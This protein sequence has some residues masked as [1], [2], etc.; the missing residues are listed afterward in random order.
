MKI[1]KKTRYAIDAV[2]YIHNL[3]SKDEDTPRISSKQ[4]ATELGLSVHF[5][6][7]VMRELRI[8]GILKSK[9]GPGGGYLLGHKIESITL[10]SILNAIN[11][12]IKLNR[13][14]QNHSTLCKEL[15]KR[16]QLEMNILADQPL[17][18]F[19]QESY[20]QPSV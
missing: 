19:L 14:D 17:I 13:P 15:E 3:V 18:S 9:K 1:T 16:L 10:N 12:S 11:E 2:G 4:I 6:S 5:L 7:L 20:E 8:A